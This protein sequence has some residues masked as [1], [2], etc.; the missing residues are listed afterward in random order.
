MAGG[1][2]SLQGLALVRG[3]RGL[4]LAGA[5]VVDILPEHDV[6]GLTALLAA[7]LVWEQLTLVAAARLQE[8]A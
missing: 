8:G 7:T 3:C 1:P 5:D 2:S 4:R 6:A